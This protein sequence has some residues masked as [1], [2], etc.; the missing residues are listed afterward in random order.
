MG[1]EEEE[2]VTAALEEEEVDDTPEAPRSD[3]TANDREK[4]KEIL[5]ELDPDD[6]KYKV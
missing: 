5:D 3:F 4:W 1:G 2:Q 6:F